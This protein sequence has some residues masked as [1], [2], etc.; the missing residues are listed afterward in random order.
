M[1][2]MLLRL[3]GEGAFGKVYKGESEYQRRVGVSVV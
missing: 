2:W 3:F 1:Q